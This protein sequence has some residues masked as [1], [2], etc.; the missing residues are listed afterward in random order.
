MLPA[1]LQGPLQ[2]LGG[3][4]IAGLPE[5]GHHRWDLFVANRLMHLEAPTRNDALMV[6]GQPRVQADHHVDRLTAVF[7]LER[8][9]LPPS[10]KSACKLLSSVLID[11]TRPSR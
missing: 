10:S 4:R 5:G 3:Q 11:C 7:A 8:L 9:K 6:I 2:H 1:L